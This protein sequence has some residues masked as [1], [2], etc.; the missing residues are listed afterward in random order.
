LASSLVVDLVL[1]R[2][3]ARLRA[4][5]GMV[6]PIPAQQEDLVRQETYPVIQ[7]DLVPV[8]GYCWLKLLAVFSSVSHL[9]WLNPG[10]THRVRRYLVLVVHYRQTFNYDISYLRKCGYS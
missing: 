4:R 10:P 2:R 5:H 1:Q 7:V 3:G 8:V 6:H 9:V